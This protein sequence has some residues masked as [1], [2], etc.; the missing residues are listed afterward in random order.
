MAPQTINAVGFLYTCRDHL[1]IVQRREIVW[2]VEHY[3]THDTAD[4]GECIWS[5]VFERVFVGG[6][7][8]ELWI[9]SLV[10]FK[11]D[12]MPPIDLGCVSMS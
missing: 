4:R 2:N 9:L 3:I 5:D 10:D 12:T 1:G 7:V 11:G 6:R 8:F